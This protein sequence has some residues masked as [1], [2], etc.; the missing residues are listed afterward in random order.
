MS[1]YI[2]PKANNFPGLDRGFNQRF[3]LDDNLSERQG[4]G[5]YLVTDAQDIIQTLNNIQKYSPKSGEIKVIAG[6]HCYE[7]FTFQSAADTDS[8]ARTRFVIDLSNMR[9]I[10]EEKINNIDYVVIEP[11]ASNWLIQ[12]TLHSLYGAAVPGGSCYSVCAGGH[13]AGGGYGLLSRLH[14]LTV[15]Y[16]AG[17]EMVIPGTQNGGFKRRTFTPDA[18]A[19]RL[20]WACRG[21]GS[22]HFGIITKYY[23]EKTRVP[24]APERALFIAL[25]VPWKQFAGSGGSGAA[26]F[27]AFMQAY[28]DACNALPGQAFALGKFSCMTAET[29]VMSIVMQVVYGA[30]TRHDAALG[31]KTIEALASKDAALNVIQSFASRL[32]KWIAAPETSAW[33]KQ[34]LSLP[35]HPVSAAISLD[36]VYDLPWI[37]MTQL[38]SGSGENQNGKY[39]SCNMVANFTASEAAAMYAFL[40]NTQNGN[41]APASADLSQTL[42]QVDSY[43]LQINNMD[44]A[45][46]AHTAIAARNCALKLQYQTYWKTLEGTTP[47]QAKRSEQDIVSW[48]NAGYNAIYR[49]GTNNASGFPVWG[50]RYQGCYFNYP[51]KQLGVNPDYKPDP[52]EQY[53]DFTQIYF[54]DAVAEKLK[55]IKAEIDPNNVFAFAQSFLN[56]KG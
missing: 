7:N 55:A 44:D 30:S 11:G 39:K 1:T 42:I 48:F 52:G 4:E 14:G 8:G 46:R 43:G 53:G 28:Y 40:T 10:H 24:K 21:G 56:S 2:S 9:G 38:L 18:D 25:P 51:D 26:G 23:F 17:V 54:G 22:G 36:T 49:Q 15:D 33:R 41:P 5:V 45:T 29:D 27:G 50:D 20:D 35:G 12:Q 31:G 47:E 19:D 6:G 3:K 37:D 34:A 13:V 16:L 32:N